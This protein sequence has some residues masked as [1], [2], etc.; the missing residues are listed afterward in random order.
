MARVSDLSSRLAKRDIFTART[1][2][3]AGTGPAL[4]R[5]SSPRFVAAFRLAKLIGT[6]EEL[7]LIRNASARGMKIEVFSPKAIGEPLGID[8]GDQVV[9]PARV[10]RLEGDCVGIALNEAI[11]VAFAFGKVPLPGDRRGRRLRF[12]IDADG[13]IGLNRRQK[14]CQIVEISQGGARVFTDA[15]MFVA[16]RISLELRDLGTLSGVTRWVRNGYAGIAFIR[17]LPYR[18][19][20]GWLANRRRITRAVPAI[21]GIPGR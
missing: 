20:A 10:V 16:E 15:A 3:S 14:Q 11:D 8:L 5:R 6:G 1:A 2:V 9:R 7:C 17:P 12:A 13:V 21:N 4:E 19:L 18:E